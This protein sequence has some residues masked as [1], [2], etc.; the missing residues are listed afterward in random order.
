MKSHRVGPE[1]DRLKLRA[2][3]D[4]DAEAFYQLN[5]DPEVMRFTGEPPL[6]SIREA[7][8]AIASYPD[9]DSIGYGRWGCVMKGEESI[10]GFC[11]LKYLEELHAVDVGFRF[12]PQYWGKGFA[13][14]ACHA[15][16]QFGFEVL[17][18]THIIALVLPENFASVRVLEKVGMKLEGNVMYEGLNPL[19]YGIH[20]R[21]PTGIHS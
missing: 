4:D 7:R 19:R 3:S 15:S 10:F 18:L 5:S 20:N 14:E 8:E 17:G 16:V 21:Q 13:T 11:G 2:L 9:F 12:L 1:T 6:R